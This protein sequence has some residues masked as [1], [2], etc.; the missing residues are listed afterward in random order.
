MKF[1]MILLTGLL[2]PFS[3]SSLS[4]AQTYKDKY[5]NKTGSFKNG[6]FKDKYG[7]KTGSFK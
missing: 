7:N 3:I 6:T 2:I 4:E 1:I 5:G